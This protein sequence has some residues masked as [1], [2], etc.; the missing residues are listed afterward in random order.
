MIMMNREMKRFNHLISEINALYHE[1]ALKLGISDSAMNILYTV[2]SKDDVCLIS[3]VCRLTGISKQTINSALRKLEED[4]IVYLEA[5]DGRHKSIHLTESG[6]T[7]AGQTA[8]KIIEIE[9][10]VFEAWPKDRR[11]LYLTLTQEYLD[12]FQN[13]I[14]QTL[15][16]SHE[17]HNS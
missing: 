17:N 4:G 10:K 14:N 8:M 7:L 11:K 12:M 9:N 15:G 1:A 2:C 3:D 6:E 13:E 5:Y 16:G